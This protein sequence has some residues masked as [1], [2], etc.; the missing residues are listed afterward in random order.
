MSD[1][2]FNFAS[3]FKKQQILNEVVGNIHENK[4]IFEKLFAFE[5]S[6]QT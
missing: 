6:S 3:Y 5:S 4:Q 1:K 2:T